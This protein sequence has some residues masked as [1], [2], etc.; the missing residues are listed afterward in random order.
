MNRKLT[1]FKIVFHL[2]IF[3][4]ST[5]LQAGEKI[6]LLLLSGKNNHEWQKTTPKLQ[7]IF[8]NSNLFSVTVTERPDTLS[9]KSL[10]SFQLIVSNWNAFPEKSRQWSAETENAIINFVKNG[11]GFVFVHSAS[12]THYDWPEFQNMAGGTWGDTTKHGKV[13]PFQVEISKTDHPV[14]K[15]LANFRTTDELWV[16]MRINGKPTVLG[17]AFAP[18]SNRGSDELEPVILTQKSGKGRSF[19][20]VLGHNVQAMRNL[21][22]QTLLLRGSEWAASG[23]VTQKIPDELS[24]DDQSRKLSWQKE[25]NSVSL[26]NNGKIVWQHHFD[27]KEGKPYFHPLSTIDGSV[28]T[29][30]RPDDHPW[31]RAIWFSWKFINGINYWEEDRATGK[32]EGITELKSVRYNLT[33]QFGAEFNLELTY[34]PPTGN[35]LLKEK[36]SVHM[37]APAGDGSYFMDWEST[38]TALADEVVLDRTP[39]LNEPEGK[40]YGG[41]AGFSARLNNQLWDVKVI[42]DSGETEQLHGKAS[43]WM[44]YEA[45][46]LKGQSV[47]MTIFDHP[48][49]LNHPNKWFISN[50]PETPFYYFS[51]AVIFDSKLILKKGE[52]LHLKYRLLVS[53][54]EID[55]TKLQSTWNQFK[56]K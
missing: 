3:F 24:L 8:N 2:A 37:S 9:E 35:D 41:Y 44:I 55:Q 25:A 50:D 51:P 26:L 15:G 38:F 40:S 45:K 36:R 5:S 4:I 46:N 49:N 34:H 27:K 43:R 31:H 17:N 7:E 47:A 13:A 33:K 23:K 52:K 1:T 48:A 32:S 14:T 28:L 56:T 10:K 16:D 53:T 20:L 54:G 29:G 18:S 21:G 42:N 12:A 6:N 39:L 19:F 30:L 22:F 11:G